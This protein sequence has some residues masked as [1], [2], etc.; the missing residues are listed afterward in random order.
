[1]RSL[2]TTLVFL[3][4]SS[5]LKV[6]ILNRL[7][8]DVHPASIVGIN[9]VRGLQRLEIAE[10]A[11]IGNFNAFLGVQ[12]VRLGVG[13][14]VHYLNFFTTGY[15]G[16]SASE[17]QEYRNTL[18]MGEH[19]RIITLHNIDCTGGFLVGENCW[20][21]GLRSTVLTHAFDPVNGGIIVDPV[22]MKKGSVLATNCTLLPGST[23]GEGALL[24]AGSTLWTGQQLA[25]ECLH[26]GVPAR[27]LS[28]IK[29]NDWVY[30]WQR[31][32]GP[33]IATSSA[34][35]EERTDD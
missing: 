21:T 5:G 30:S 6:K 13:A 26:G 32:G 17:R 19:S 18:Q 4:P 33:A 3:L 2:L 8:H 12:H 14:R 11:G 20:V 22:E 28:P 29:I 24:A 15:S 10:G 34:A 35:V 9:L 25:A 31:Y 7:G 23:V 16:P 1:M 27:R